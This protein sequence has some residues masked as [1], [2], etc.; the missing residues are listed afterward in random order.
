MPD[1]VLSDGPS[2]RQGRGR[3][4]AHR[5]RQPANSPRHQRSAT[6]QLAWG[7]A[8]TWL[9]HGHPYTPS[10]WRRLSNPGSP[11]QPAKPC[12]V[13]IS[14][15]RSEMKRAR[16]GQGLRSGSCKKRLVTTLSSIH[17]PGVPTAPTSVVRQLHTGGATA[18]TLP[19]SQGHL[20]TAL[21]TNSAKAT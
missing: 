19:R 5:L 8:G 14:R 2:P 10:A 18:Q 4:R 12:P 21:L 1:Q 13:D 7:T 6:P 17:G 20:Q 15:G 16:V 11:P 3:R 9:L